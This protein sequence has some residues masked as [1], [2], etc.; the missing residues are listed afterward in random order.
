M[1]F[2]Q[3]YKGAA[4]SQELK[5]R[6]NPS[7]SNLDGSDFIRAFRLKSGVATKRSSALR[8]EKNGT[9]CRFTRWLSQ[10]SRLDETQS[11]RHR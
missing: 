11:R 6:I 8:A 7:T 1:F 4:Q 5:A 3:K 2:P 10:N 9:E